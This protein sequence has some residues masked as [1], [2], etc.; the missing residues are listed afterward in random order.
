MCSRGSRT[1]PAHINGEK[2]N[3]FLAETRTVMEPV[4]WEHKF[5]DILGGTENGGLTNHNPHWTNQEILYSKM[6]TAI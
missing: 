2:I 1:H 4:H 3:S 6:T 5:M